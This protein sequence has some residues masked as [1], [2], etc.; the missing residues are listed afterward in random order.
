MKQLSQGHIASK[1][2]RQ[3]SS[4]RRQSTNSPDCQGPQLFLVGSPDSSPSCAIC[5]LNDLNQA[6]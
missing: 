5:W 4:S 6:T 3:A 1:W 2:Q